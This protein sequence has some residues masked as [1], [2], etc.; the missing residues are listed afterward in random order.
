MVVMVNDVDGSAC[1]RTGRCLRVKVTDV[2]VVVGSFNAEGYGSSVM[3]WT[4]GDGHRGLVLGDG[5][6]SLELSP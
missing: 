5:I 4:W 2:N 1:L 6:V 3:S